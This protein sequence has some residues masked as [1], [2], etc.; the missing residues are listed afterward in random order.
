MGNEARLENE[1]DLYRSLLYASEQTSPADGL[2]EVLSLAP[3]TLGVD[4]GYLE[5]FAKASS[6]TLAE[7]HVGL[8]GVQR[9]LAQRRISQTIVAEALA[10]GRMVHTPSALLDALDRLFAG[11]S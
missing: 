4:Q 1:R 6:D 10:A 8:A 11:D 5:I 3:R 9:A 7:L 2:A